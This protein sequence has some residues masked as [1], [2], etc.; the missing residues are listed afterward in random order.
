MSA[1]LDAAGRLRHL[2]TLDGL[3]PSLLRALLECARGYVRTPHAPAPRGRD[4]EGRTVA[5]LFLEP[6]TRTRVSF[7][8]AAR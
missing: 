3:P 5:N 4:L 2:L 6:S 8:L 1:Q 7:E